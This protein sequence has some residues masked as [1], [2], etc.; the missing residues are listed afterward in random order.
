MTSRIDRARPSL[1]AAAAL[2]GSLI[3]RTGARGV[4]LVT[5]LL[6]V[7]A[8]CAPATPTDR[9]RPSPSAPTGDASFSPSP[10]QP[11]DDD[12]GADDDPTADDGVTATDRFPIV[13]Y[14]GAE[15]LGAEELDFTELLG[16]GTPVALNFWAGQCPPCRA[17]MPAF[18]RVY[19]RHRDEFLLVGVDIGPFVFLGSRAD[20][21]ALLAELSIT[22]P[23]AYAV[24]DRAVR[25]HNI[26]SMPTTIFYTGDGR[27]HSRH[28][29][30]MTQE[31]FE[32]AVEQ[33]IA[34]SR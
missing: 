4:V 25:D 27:E 6:L 23:T 16:R 20:A 1:L 15:L 22:Y 30:L 19:E 11:S 31:Q 3:G 18:Q 34:A 10:T 2:S 29:G 5:V 21:R 26:I 8:A 17:E 24:D 9:D 7:L 14:Q 12:A 33:I 32:E 28:N 13:A